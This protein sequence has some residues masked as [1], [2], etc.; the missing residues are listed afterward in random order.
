MPELN[1][2]SSQPSGRPVQAEA[3]G[4]RYVAFVPA[5]LPPVLTPEGELFRVASNAAYALGEL[6]ALGRGLANP[7]LLLGPFLRKEAVLSSRIE[8]TQAGI[9]DLY[10]YEAGQQLAAARIAGFA[11]ADDVQEV[12]NYVRALEYGIERLRTLPIGLQLVQEVHERLMQGVRGGAAQ[13]GQFR[14]V[15]NW[16]GRYGTTLRNADYVPPPPPEM[17]EALDAL[18]GYLQSFTDD[19]PPLVRLAFIHYQ[20][21]AIHPFLD[22]NGRVGRLLISLLL[23][24]WDLLPLP[25]LYLSAYFERH[26]SL[27]YDLLL[28]VSRRSAWREWVLFFLNGVVEQARDASDRARRLNDLRSAWRDRLTEARAS[29][30][31][32]KLAD[33]LFVSPLLNIPQAQK[34]LD[35]AYPTA[36][37]SVEKLVEAG[38]LQQAGE[39]QYGK[40]YAA[41]E[42]LSVVGEPLDSLNYQNED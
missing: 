11:P 25:L 15:Q 5:P 32:L 33:S 28:A 1:G 27:Y 13:P 26:R 24:S 42:I 39:Q 16:I 34:A 12:L 14:S 4:I 36:Q 9:A 31:A 17:L 6:A 20:F 40:T 18:E 21:E 22:G 23:Q 35:V 19:H 10:A 38:I 30:H 3:A 29:S 7:H 2:A 8:G 37:R 41:G